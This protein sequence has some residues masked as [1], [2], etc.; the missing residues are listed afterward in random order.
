[1]NTNEGK[2]ARGASRLH[3]ELAAAIAKRGHLTI[4]DRPPGTYWLRDA[5]DR[6]VICEKFTGRELAKAGGLV[7]A[8]N[9]AWAAKE[10]ANACGEPGH[11]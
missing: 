4:C 2:D 9:R 8:L 6:W 10:A 5:S 1:M 3:A 7:L 11:D